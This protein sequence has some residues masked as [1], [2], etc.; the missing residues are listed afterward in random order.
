MKDGVILSMEAT[1]AEVKAIHRRL[2]CIF[3]LSVSSLD[4]REFCEYMET[5]HQFPDAVVSRILIPYLQVPLPD[6]IDLRPD[7]AYSTTSRQFFIT[8]Q[9]FDMT[10]VLPAYE[11][12]MGHM[13]HLRG[14]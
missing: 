2:N 13:V 12:T 5:V 14:I 9:D 6:E 4:R 7:I 3:S 10:P 11:N 1:V 8:G